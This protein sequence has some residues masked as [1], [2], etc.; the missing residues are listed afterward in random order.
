MSLQWEQGWNQLPD[1]HLHRHRRLCRVRPSPP[2]P[3]SSFHFSLP[4]FLP[5]S[6][7][8]L[9]TKNS[10]ANTLTRSLFAAVL[11]LVALPLF[12]NL[13]PGRACSILGGVA[14]GLSTVPFV[15]YSTSSFLFAAAAVQEVVVLEED[16]VDDAETD[17]DNDFEQSTD[18]S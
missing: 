15:F 9:T 7:T 2:P 6:L 14:A 18:R 8:L 5:S 11:P 10:A 12:N 4:S 13:G 16:E 3:P 17:D 1:R